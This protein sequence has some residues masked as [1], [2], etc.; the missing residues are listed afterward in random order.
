MAGREFLGALLTKFELIFSPRFNVT[1]FNTCEICNE[2][3][4]NTENFI[5]KFLLL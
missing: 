3:T 5:E 1:L 4:Y 2:K